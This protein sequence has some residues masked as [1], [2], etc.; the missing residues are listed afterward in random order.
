MVR[1]N[2]RRRHDEDTKYRQ[3]CRSKAAQYERLRGQYVD[4]VDGLSSQ[5]LLQLVGGVKVQ[6]MNDLK[7]VVLKQGLEQID[8]LI[9]HWTEEAEQGM[10]E[11]LEA[12]RL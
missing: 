7:D 4:W 5:N 6:R 12:A 11:P 8:S 10:V 2:V 1:I 9:E 3:D